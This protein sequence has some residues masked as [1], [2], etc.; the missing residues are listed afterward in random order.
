MAQRYGRKQKRAAREKIAELERHVQRQRDEAKAARSAEDVAEQTLERYVTQVK[1]WDQDLRTELGHRSAF[2]FDTALHKEM[3]AYKLRQ[4]PVRPR[5]S[6]FAFEE[7]AVAMASAEATFVQVYRF[8]IDVSDADRMELSR[9]IRLRITCGD[10]PVW[11]PG[12]GGKPYNWAYAISE[13]MLRRGMPER[14]ML[15][16]AEQVG[17]QFFHRLK[18]EFGRK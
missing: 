3:A 2:R 9:Y 6:S 18:A 17:A 16:I 14:D 5:L 1:A 10:E 11:S 7:A 4:M 15:H 8:L 12:E 13:D